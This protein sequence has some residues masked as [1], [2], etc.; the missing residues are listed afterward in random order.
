MRRAGLV[1]LAY[2]YCDFRDDKKKDLRGLVSSLLV[3]LCHQS[4]SYCDIVSKFY[5]EHAKGSHCPRDA[6]LVL[7]LKGLLKLPGQTPVY[8]IVDA[9]DEC[10]TTSDMP[11]AR[12]KV[13]MLVRQLT[14]SKYPNLRI[15]VTSRLE[16]D[17]SVVLEPYRSVPSPYMTRVDKRRTSPA[18]SSQSSTRIRKW[19]HGQ[20]TTRNW[21]L[22]YSHTK[23]TGCE[24]LCLGD[25]QLLLTL[26]TDSN[27]LPYRSPTFATALGEEYSVL[28]T[29]YQR[30]SMGPI[31]VPCKTSKR[32]IVHCRTVFSA[33]S[34]W[35]AARS[36]PRN[37]Q[38]F[39]RLIS[40]ENHLGYFVKVGTKRIW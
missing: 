39:S 1:S 34:P 36:V 24:P 15:C 2:Y 25:T 8:L 21:S 12:E 40:R 14:T 22:M 30:R 32:Q 6:A 18:I 26:N 16:P 27:W 28:W 19:K 38:N 13:L 23:L 31:G 9:L 5:S 33:A 20:P 10:P 29:I 7:C 17:L 35:P 11:P 37:L 3:Q 4:D